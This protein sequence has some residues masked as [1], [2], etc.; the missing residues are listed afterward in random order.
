MNEWSFSRARRGPGAAKDEDEWH[1]L[2]G[3][4]AQFPVC[5]EAFIGQQV[6]FNLTCE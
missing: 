4:A 2:C 5:C 1:E 6:F 3:F